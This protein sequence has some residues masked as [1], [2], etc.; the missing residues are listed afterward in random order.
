MKTV[1]Q[2]LLSASGITSWQ[3]FQSLT[4]LS[5]SNLTALDAE[6]AKALK[7]RNISF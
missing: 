4:E 2:T 5:L 7:L 3:G 1:Q 6:T